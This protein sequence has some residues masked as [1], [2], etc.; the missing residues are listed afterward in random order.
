[1]ELKLNLLERYKL[2]KLLP[3]EGNYLTVSIVRKAVDVLSPSPDEH[4]EFEVRFEKDMTY[5][6]IKGNEQRAIVLDDSAA[7]LLEQRFAEIEKAGKLE[8]ELIALYEKVYLK[9]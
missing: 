4:K 7:K 9:K 8:V 5:W 6:N 2:I 1:M 3:T